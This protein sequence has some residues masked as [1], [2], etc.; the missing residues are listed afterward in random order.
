MCKTIVVAWQ[1][2]EKGDDRPYL[3]RSYDHT[4]HLK[5]QT[6]VRNPGSA[7][8]VCIWEAARATTA[9]PTYFAD[10]KINGYVFTDGGFGANNPSVLAFN[11]V[12]QMCGNKDSAVRALI[13]IG[14]GKSRP[15]KRVADSWLWKYWYYFNAARKW[16]TQSEERHHDMTDRAESIRTFDYVRF[17]VEEGLEFVK[18]DQWET[19]SKP[20]ALSTLDNISFQTDKYVKD[21]EEV[22]EK[23]AD[24]LVKFRKTRVQQSFSKW[25]RF[26]QGVSYSCPETDC[27]KF[28]EKFGDR[29]GLRRHICQ[30]HPRSIAREAFTF[31]EE[32]QE[33]RKR[34]NE[35]RHPDLYP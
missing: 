18:L 21:Q 32:C 31:E 1:R 27:S 14:T 8:M 2:L 20:N 7:D 26:A 15:I 16:A 6:L 23:Y 9:A 28:N 17:N 11:E 29:D 12:K 13:S 4:H 3:F 19:P 35:C 34:L 25:E 5:K 24:L 22:I 10:A 33:L 30:Y